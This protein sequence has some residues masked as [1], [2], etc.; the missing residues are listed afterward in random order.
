MQYSIGQIYAS[1]GKDI[2]PENHQNMSIEDLSNN[3][4]TNLAEWGVTYQATVNIPLDEQ[5][6]QLLIINDPIN[7]TQK[8]N[9]FKISNDTFAIT[10]PG[11]LRYSVTQEDGTDLPRWL[12]FLTSDLSIV[13]NP[14]DDVSGIKLKMTVANA[15]V[16]AEDNFI[17]KFVDEETFLANESQKAR[18]ELARM[19]R[20]SNEDEILPFLGELIIPIIPFPPLFV[21]L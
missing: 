16:S 6:P 8:S 14:P 11:K 7:T 21:T 17:L 4:K 2:L 1:I 20:L 19:T 5:S 15:L 9:K 10:G 18:E 3:I 13:G 12:A